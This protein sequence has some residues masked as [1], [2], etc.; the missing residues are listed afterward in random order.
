MTTVQSGTKMTLAEYRDREEMEGGVCELI[1]G[2][3]YQM[4]PATP[5]HQFLIDFLVRMMNNWVN[6]IQPIPGLAFT[7]VGLSLSDLYAPTPDIVYP[8]DSEPALDTARDGRRD[9]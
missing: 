3:F 2:E 1:N 7:N 6:S 8:A 4:P 5:E 9:P